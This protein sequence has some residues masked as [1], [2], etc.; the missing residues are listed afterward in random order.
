MSH[1]SGGGFASN[2]MTALGLWDVVHAVMCLA[3]AAIVRKVDEAEIAR[4]KRLAKEERKRADV[5]SA[6]LKK[7]SSEDL[8]ELDDGEESKAAA[9]GTATAAAANTKEDTWEDIEARER[10][11]REREEAMARREAALQQATTR[12]GLH[13]RDDSASTQL[14]TKLE[15]PAPETDAPKGEGSDDDN[16]KLVHELEKEL[17]DVQEELAH[18]RVQQKETQ[19]ALDAMRAELSNLRVEAQRLHNAAS[20]A[21]TWEEV[22]TLRVQTQELRVELAA[23]NL[24]RDALAARVTELEDEVCQLQDDVDVA[25]AAAP[26]PV[27]PGVDESV[28]KPALR[29]SNGSGRSAKKVSFD[30]KAE[31]ESADGSSSPQLSHDAARLQAEVK[32]LRETLAEREQACNEEN[33]RV[34]RDTAEIL[35]G[36]EMRMRDEVSELQ[37]KLNLACLA[38]AQRE[39]DAIKREADATSKVP[40]PLNLREKAKRIWKRELVETQRERAAIARERA[41]EARE[42]AAIESAA[43]ASREAAAEV[44]KLVAESRKRFDEREREAQRLLA[45]RKKTGTVTLD[46]E[47]SAL[48][49]EATIARHAWSQAEAVA[50]AET[51]ARRKVEKALDAQRTRADKLDCERKRGA[52]SVSHGN[53]FAP[54]VSSEVDVRKLMI[55][56]VVQEARLSIEQIRQNETVA[57]KR[58]KAVKDLRLKYHPDKHPVMRWLFEDVSKVVNAET[59]SLMWT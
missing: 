11:V 27:T 40:K 13:R 1:G 53:G 54:S 33:G 16:E 10:A 55:D 34:R 56:Q 47:L 59:E 17:A 28:P 5:V 26:L 41:A 51:E 38:A 52:E 7:L 58:R 35:K 39:A 19:T 9:T 30:D 44:S 14:D 3:T 2:A 18:K 21:P 49:R 23:A 42:R 4:H 45:D 46:D 37:A 50:Q 6:K 22:S 25:A 32:M 20:L 43:A 29:R 57:D 36:A 31:A 15:A 8:K 24:D 12:P 48:R